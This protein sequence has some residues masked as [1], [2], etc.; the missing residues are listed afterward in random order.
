M[1]DK[2]PYISSTGSLTKAVRQLRT[3]LPAKIDATVLR[4]LGLAPKNESYL[5]NV[6][7]YLNV[8]DENGAPTNEARNTFTQ[9]DDDAFGEKLSEM[10]SKG[11]IPSFSRFTRG[12]PGNLI[13]TP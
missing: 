10:N 9:H 12:R 1:A 3:S 11:H 2:H 5:M 7:R 4:K 6:L 13:I 8:I